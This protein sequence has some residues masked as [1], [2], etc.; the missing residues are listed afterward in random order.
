[1]ADFTPHEAP[2]HD[3]QALPVMQ[4]SKH[5]GRDRVLAKVYEHLRDNMPVLLYGPAGVGKTTLA[6]VLASAYTD[7]PGGVLW[8]HVQN[9]TL[10]DLLVSV[11]RA[12]DIP[13]IT[14]RDN[15]LAM[16]GAVANTLTAN[17]PLVVLDGSFDAEVAQAFITRCADSLPVLLLADEQLVGPWAAEPLARLEPEQAAALFKHLTAAGHTDSDAADASIDALV[18]ALDFSPFA[19]T[20]AAGAVIATKQEPAAF[21]AALPRQPGVSGP[22][23]ALTASF[24][25]L[26]SA[27]QGLVLIL[28]AT[29]H[30]E[31][32]NELLSLMSGAPPEGIRQAMLLLVQ[33]G[34][35]QRF[36]RYNTPYYR[37]HPIVH[38]FAQPLLRGSNKLDSLRTKVRD[39]LLQYAGNHSEATTADY[40]A[41]ATE[42]DSIMAL[43]DWAAEDGDLETVRQLAVALTQAGDFVQERGYVYEL[44]T[45]QKQAASSTNAFPAYSGGTPPPLPYE[46]VADAEVDEDEASE[47]DDEAEAVESVIAAPLPLE[48]LSPA[49]AEDEPDDEDLSSD[50]GN[51]DDEDLL[52]EDEDDGDDFYPSLPYDLLGEDAY[53]DDEDE[54]EDDADAESMTPSSMAPLPLDDV[55]E[56]EGQGDEAADDKAEPEPETPEPPEMARLRTSLSQARQQGNQ[57]RQAE[58]LSQMGQALVAASMEN[59]AIASFSEALTVY[60]ELED[61]AGIL[62][63]LETLAALTARTENSQAAV[64][65]ATRGVQVAE[66]TG[67]KVRQMHLLSILGDAR[68]QLGE[69]E[70]A[71]GAY[72][73]ALD[74]AREQQNTE[75][76]AQILLR[77]GYA[78]LDDGRVQAAV[79]SWEAALTLFKE[80]GKRDLEGRVLG[81]LG[82]AYG[83]LGR[84]TEAIAFHTAALFIAREVSDHDEEALQLSNLGYASVQAQQLGQAVLRYRQAL[85]LAYVANSRD[86]IISMITDLVN[87]LVESPR[88]LRIAELLADEALR[89]EPND[90]NVKR[91]KERVEDELQA[92]SENGVQWTPVT[93]TVQDYAANAYKLLES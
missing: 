36:Q 80:Q 53:E 2:A 49:E 70:Q 37:L 42:M 16:V 92:A 65:H 23:L 82:T 34:L 47:D 26:N 58:L 69:A 89:L 38:A 29:F 12:Y 24:R 25:S 11:G 78:Q 32:S 19:I 85:H 57:H 56:D 14:N 66:Q 81:G 17:K 18:E 28:G 88:H 76:E 93:G 63:S 83:E 3:V 77:L 7:L 60:E 31:A 74:A 21:L 45:L 8:M 48:P 1:M 67:D 71:I 90:R 30:G 73:L 39:T 6:A 40:N 20:V 46:D 52:D 64:L 33:R 9:P 44:A 4:P 62:R 5:I 84:W 55:D 54:D 22:L 87:L 41:L 91:L 27:L 75:E 50:A 13:E 35:A 43:A 51:E 72:N 68:Q 15:P 61:R 79:A 86:N 10:A 59:E